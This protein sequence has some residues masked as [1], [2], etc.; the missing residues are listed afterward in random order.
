[1][2][3]RIVTYIV[4]YLFI[5]SSEL[6]ATQ[7]FQKLSKFT[8]EHGVANNTIL[9]LFQDSCGM[10]WIGTYEGLC[11]YNGSEF[12]SYPVTDSLMGYAIHFI[13]RIDNKQLILGTDKGN[14]LFSVHDRSFTPLFFSNQGSAS[15][16]ALFRINNR[17]FIGTQSGIYEYEPQTHTAIIRDNHSISCKQISPEG[18][19]CLGSEEQGIWEAKLKDSV[20]S[21]SPVYPELQKEKVLS[22]Q[23][24]SDGTPVVLT[25]KGLWLQ[26]NKKFNLE[27]RG[28]FSSL[29]L[30]QQNEILLGTHGDFIQQV[31]QRGSKFVLKDY[32]S[33]DNEILND[34]YDAQINVLFRDLSGA[35]WIG[36]NRAGL[37]KIDRK[38]ITFNKYKSTIQ[39]SEPEAG[40]INAL[41]Q[42]EDGNIWIG[43]SGKGLHYLD[44]KKK[45]LIP[46]T[47]SG[48]RSDSLFIEAI[49]QYQNTLYIGTR[50]KG[51]ITAK[52][53]S[54]D[55][56]KLYASGRLF[57]SEV[58]L[59]K[60]DYIYAL[61]RFDE[62]LYICSSKGTFVYGFDDQIMVKIDS[63]PSINVKLD[64][65]SNIWILSSYM[66]LYH[67]QKKIELGMEV[68]DFYFGDN[69]DVWA[70]TSKGLALINDEN[71]KPHFYNPP[72]KVIEF[73]SIGKDKE[74]QFWLGSRMGIY[75]FDPQSKLFA[76]YQIPGGS[77][78][79]SFNHAKLLHS[80]SGEFY[81][82]S[83]DGVVS[84]IPSANSY[85]PKPLFEV[86]QGKHDNP[87]VFEVY[88]YS[89]NHQAENGIAYRFSHPDSSWKYLSGN[90]SVLDFSSLGKGS[91][92]LDISAV[93]ADGIMNKDYK[94]FQFQIKNSLNAN[95][96]LWFI[97][98]IIL[99]G[100]SLW[101]WRTRQMLLSHV[102]G[103]E[104]ESISLPET[105]ED[106]IHK[107][108]MKDDFMQKAILIIEDN[109]SNN[110][111][112]VNELYAG[113]QMSKS[114]FYRKL[115]TIT[116]LSP[117]E[118]I[119]FIRL[120]KSS[121]LLVE[122]KLSVN[123]IA[124][125][126]GFNS[127]SYFTRCF[128]QQFGIAP[129]EY[130]EHYDTYCC[131]P[132]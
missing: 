113:M 14:L 38:K 98:L 131:K 83:N 90:H 85:L 53:S 101:Y 59:E 9:S 96:T 57:S 10:M 56:S 44:E 11:S 26:Q 109:L 51:I 62:K 23:F 7:Y 105:P 121:K 6:Q 127:P 33:R 47:I 89:F 72:E 87:S 32:I 8:T 107:E 88:N 91:Y 94:S 4:V 128:K 81:W 95:I 16:S 114:N 112:G 3:R 118:L 66:E 64:S 71:T 74:G 20:L 92:Q 29:I 108:W 75:R 115:K 45:E 78:A 124:Y 12:I 126:V 122:S 68:S 123:E 21:L 17:A 35:L 63:I 13:D 55:F 106:K 125:D 54:K 15:V 19:I 104:D 82:G 103:E 129:S 22:I 36:T 39:S 86:I 41:A 80:F 49:L 30:S 43:T 70:A 69:N 50:F 84:I 2:H 24:K 120:W 60:E 93:N 77:K 46:V 110:S 76:D 40:Y 67:N 111:Y 61:K 116:D 65:L 79:N 18:K 37:D 73:T 58:G 48:V 5:C 27:I 42:G 25:E 100:G 31:Y 102:A 132:A 34:Y 117:N 1:M 28:S 99:T 119:R 52:Y 130:K 97:F